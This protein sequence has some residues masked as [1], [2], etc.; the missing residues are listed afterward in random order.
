[1]K[2]VTIGFALMMGAGAFANSPS[3]PAVSSGK[4]VLPHGGKLKISQ[5]QIRAAVTRANTRKVSD[6]N[7]AK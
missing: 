1:M 7:K 4:A 3:L 2:I 6:P 5:D